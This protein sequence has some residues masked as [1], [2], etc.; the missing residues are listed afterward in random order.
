MPDD[1]KVADIV[2]IFKKGQRNLAANYRLVSLTSVVS[3]VMESI[4]RDHM[5]SFLESN[6]ALSQEQHGF[7]QGW[8]CLTNL[9][10]TV[11]KWVECIDEGD[12]V[13]VVY[14]DV[15]KAFDTVPHL[16]LLCKWKILD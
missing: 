16:R 1:W 15:R 10:E 9:V 8:S 12:G 11:E 13:D 4:L 6:D 7:T 14:L 3:K 5:W 2:P